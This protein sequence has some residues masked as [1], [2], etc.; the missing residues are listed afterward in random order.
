MLKVLVRYTYSSVFHY[1][2][3][4]SFVFFLNKDF[5]FCGNMNDV[6][7]LRKFKRIREQVYYYL[8]CPHEVYLHWNFSN[9]GYKLDS[10]QLEFGLPLQNL[11]DVVNGEVKWM[12]LKISREDIFLEHVAI[13]E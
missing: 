5:H 8:L 6:F 4:K 7:S 2:L 10:N 9:K 12:H 13:E 3:E 11:D 1:D